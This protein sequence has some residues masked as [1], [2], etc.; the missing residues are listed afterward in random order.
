MKK[1]RN[2][3]VQI[4][5]IYF[6]SYLFIKQLYVETQMNLAD[7]FRWNLERKF[8]K[9][10]LYPLLLTVLPWKRSEISQENIW[11]KIQIA[12][13]LWKN[14]CLT[15]DVCLSV[16]SK[17]TFHQIQCDVISIILMLHVYPSPKMAKIMLQPENYVQSIFLAVKILTCI[18]Y[19][20]YFQCS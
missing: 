9:K 14:A 3:H 20:Q 17:A 15:C 1:Y 19:C 11:N 8:E 10:I 5:H 6:Y 7:G 12:S 13:L 2:I 18:R 16:F 4:R